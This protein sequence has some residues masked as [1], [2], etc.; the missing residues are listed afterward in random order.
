MSLRH[1]SRDAA[2]TAA[3]AEGKP[4]TFNT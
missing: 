1:M 3:V 2:T 4:H